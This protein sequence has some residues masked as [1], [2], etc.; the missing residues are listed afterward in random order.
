[1]TKGLYYGSLDDPVFGGG[2][3]EIH[4]LREAYSAG[5][6]GTGTLQVN[7]SVLYD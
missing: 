7:K 1:M 6:L 4:L 2:G 5:E 3:Q